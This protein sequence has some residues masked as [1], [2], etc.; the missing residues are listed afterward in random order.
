[1]FGNK[2]ITADHVEFIGSDL[3]ASKSSN[4]IMKKTNE[5]RVAKC[6]SMRLRS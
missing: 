5:G 1:M 2:S 6:D 3:S 4:E